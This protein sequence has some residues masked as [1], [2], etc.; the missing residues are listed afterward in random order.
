[1]VEVGPE[2]R[3][4]FALHGRRAI[5]LEVDGLSHPHGPRG[6]LQV[7]T[8]YE[9]VTH[10]AASPGGFWL[11]TARSSY[12][13]PRRSFVDPQGPERLVGSLLAR[14]AG[15]PGGAAQLA[16]MAEVERRARAPAPVRATWS[17][18][19]LC[20]LVYALQLEQGSRLLRAGAL[21]RGLVQEGDL[22]RLVT[23]NLLHGLPEL[24]LHLLLNMI[25]LVALGSLV[26][27]ALGP[28]RTVCVM[29]A[30]GLGAML[31]GGLATP[32][33]L[34]GASGVVFGLAGALVWLE[35][36]RADRLPAWLRIPRRSLVA[37]LLANAALVLLVPF[38]SGAAHAGGFGAGLGAAAL[39]GG[40]APGPRRTP[41]WLRA[42]CAGVLLAT[43]AALLALALDLFGAGDFDARYDAR[44]LRLPRIPPLELEAR[45]R[46]I[47]GELDATRE[48]LA[49]GLRLAERAAAET[50]H[51]DAAILATLAE[52]QLL[53]GKSGEA[54]ASI[55]EAI[56]LAP[57]ERGFRA[58]RREILE[59]RARE[60]PPQEDW[61]G[62]WPGWTLPDP[63]PRP[64]ALEIQGP[65]A[66]PEASRATL[67]A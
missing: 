63:R 9:D 60:L 29:G 39:V 23:A 8:R 51:R 15:R 45:A 13:V 65:P 2:T 31:A 49:A 1:L 64:R 19:A 61:Q 55:E 26:E 56:A 24:P 18:L 36:W 40:P 42:A 47:A 50:R 46:E 21:V 38:I 37:F 35:L 14:L 58:L 12:A 66:D 67:R 30:S 32:G 33:S 6:D 16:R 28:A 54:L 41:P 20:L 52:L 5:Q 48:Q 62:P 3:D 27:R 7:F 4:T 10:V 57:R 43:A 44:L 22:W 17:L 53:L 25:G 11:G 34:V 59:R